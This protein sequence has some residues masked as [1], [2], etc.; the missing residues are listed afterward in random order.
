MRKCKP[1]G[2]DDDPDM[3]APDWHARLGVQQSIT[4]TV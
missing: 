3:C 1:D 2:M 4:R